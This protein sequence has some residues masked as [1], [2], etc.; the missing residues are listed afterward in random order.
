MKL[1]VYVGITA[2]VSAILAS[3][4]TAYYLQIPATDAERIREFYLTENAVKVSP[5]G[6]RKAMDKGTDTMILVDVRS[7]EEYVAEHITGAVNIPAYKNKDESAYD[8]VDRIVDSFRELQLANPDKDLVVYCY[9]IPCMSGRKVGK[10]LAENN[11]FVKE[12]NIG[13]N[14]WRYDWNSWNHP[15]EWA[16]TKPE[17]YITSGYEPGVNPKRTNRETCPA[18]GDVG[19]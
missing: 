18:Q 17:E 7:A 19:C 8:E 16:T 13:W 11:I 10:M 2:I 15:H 12:L 3:A 4:I 6:L 9:S 1:Y 5:H 14:E